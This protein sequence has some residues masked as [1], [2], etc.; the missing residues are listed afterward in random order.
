MTTLTDILNNGFIELKNNPATFDEYTYGMVKVH[1]SAGVVVNVFVTDIKVK[2][3][4]D[5]DE[6]MYMCKRVNQYA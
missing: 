3:V 2:G 5:I 4:E 6:L 1:V